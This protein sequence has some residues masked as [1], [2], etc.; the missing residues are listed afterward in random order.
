MGA[1]SGVLAIAA[2]KLGVANVLAVDNDPLAVDACRRNAEMNNVRVDSR[3]DDRPPA[4]RFDLVVANILAGPLIAMASGLAGCVRRDLLLAGL[5]A[6]QAAE[7]RGRFEAEGLVSVGEDHAG[8][9]VA[10]RLRA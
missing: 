7:V 10:L 1:G 8:D 9:W 4:E 5:Q 6:G 3:L 2:A